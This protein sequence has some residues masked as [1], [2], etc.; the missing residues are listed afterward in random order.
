MVVLNA[1]C[2][3][4]TR[5]DMRVLGVLLA[6]TYLS[7]GGGFGCNEE[8]V[9]LPAPDDDDATSDDDDTTAPADDGVANPLECT[10]A[11]DVSTYAVREVDVAAM[12][13]PAAAT[14]ANAWVQV[15]CP[16][17]TPTS[18]CSDQ[19]VVISSMAIWAPTVG[20]F[21][22]QSD[23]CGVD[24]LTDVAWSN[25]VALIGVDNNVTGGAE[26]YPPSVAFTQNCGCGLQF[27]VP[28]GHYAAPFSCDITRSCDQRSVEGGEAYRWDATVCRLPSFYPDHDLVF[29]LG[30]DW[31]ACRGAACADGT[32]DWIVN[33]L[34][35]WISV[36]EG[37]CVRARY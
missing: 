13:A 31:L 11:T 34:S 19:Q 17:G 12:S 36:R 16:D 10:E 14:Q 32:D 25:E 33:S 7:G 2:V 21:E 29:R 5:N 27:R 8:P 1:R 3:K 37:E 26:F 23:F 35:P 22:P 24:L 6:V 15:Q 20:Q 9:V 18:E 28:T 30:M 4:E